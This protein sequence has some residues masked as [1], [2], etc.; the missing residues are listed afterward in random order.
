MMP[1]MN[2]NQLKKLMKA[3]QPEELSVDELIFK[4]S[5]GTKKRIE[6]PQVTK[7]N[8]MG[9]AMFQVQGKIEDYEEEVEVTISDEDID[10]VAQQS[11]KNKDEARRAL[12][13][14]EG[15]IAKAIISLKE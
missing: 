12:E 9:Q 4:M 1:G 2:P 5:D 6:S 8:V 15:D 10:M 3:M 14:S 13:D 7:M 11:G